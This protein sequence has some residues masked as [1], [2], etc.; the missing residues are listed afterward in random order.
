MNAGAI[1][2]MNDNQVSLSPPE[3][4][5]TNMPTCFFLSTNILDCA[6]E[7]IWHRSAQLLA[8]LVM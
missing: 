5:V 3:A 6:K 8:H 1:K 7:F 2:S 4:F